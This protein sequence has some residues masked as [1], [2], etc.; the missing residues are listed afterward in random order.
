MP[1]ADYD[2]CDDEY[3]EWGTLSTDWDYS[4]GDREWKK[5][6]KMTIPCDTSTMGKMIERQ[7]RDE[8]AEVLSAICDQLRGDQPIHDFCPE[9]FMP[10]ADLLRDIQM[11]ELGHAGSQKESDDA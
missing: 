9:C 7:K 4:D 6:V 1:D 8:L 11:A 2:G 3:R 10:M 5:M